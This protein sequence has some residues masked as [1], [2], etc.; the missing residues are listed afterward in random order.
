M[1]VLADAGKSPLEWPTWPMVG[2]RSQPTLLEWLLLM[3]L[4][5]PMSGGSPY[6][7]GATDLAD[8][9]MAFP[10]DL[11]GVVA[12]DATTLADAGMVAAGLTDLADAGMAFPADFSGVVATG[13]SP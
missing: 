8:A 4:L 11:A 13:L 12:A 3:R 9:G 2:W 5:W 10:A 6:N 7:V 1:A